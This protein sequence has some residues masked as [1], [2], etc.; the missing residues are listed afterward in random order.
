MSATKIPQNW[1]H[2]T[3][4]SQ[5]H[6]SFSSH[7]FSTSLSEAAMH[8]NPQNWIEP[9]EK[10][11]FASKNKLPFLSQQISASSPLPTVFLKIRFF[12]SHFFHHLS[13]HG[14]I[15]RAKFPLRDDDDDF[16]LFTSLIHSTSHTAPPLP[17]KSKKDWNEDFTTLLMD[18]LEK[19]LS[20]QEHEQ[21]DTTVMVGNFNKN[22]RGISIDPFMYLG[23]RSVQSTPDMENIIFFA[24]CA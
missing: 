8:R 21:R 20:C 11:N 1:K 15:S 13:H 17:P 6:H 18:L 22:Q 14:T 24:S 7:L 9:L 19:K 23:S 12:Q 4:C 10:N 3:P 2:K 5:L 16:R